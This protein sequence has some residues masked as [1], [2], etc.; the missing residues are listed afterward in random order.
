MADKINQEGINP[1]DSP[2][3]DSH[4]NLVNDYSELMEHEAF[5]GDTPYPTIIESI[6]DQFDNY[7]GMEDRTDYV[8]IF[9]EQLH[10]SYNTAR[11]DDD[12]PHPEELVEALDRIHEDFIATMQEQFQSRLTLTIMPLEAEDRDLDEVEMII[13]KLY[14]YFIIGARNNFI[15]V[16]KN[17]IIATLP[18]IVNDSSSDEYFQRIKN[19]MTCYSPLFSTI[20]PQ[21]FLKLSDAK[22]I[23]K[24]FNE[25][26]VV[27][28]FLRKYSPKFYRNDDFQVEV[29]NEVAITHGFL[30]DIKKAAVDTFEIPRDAVFPG[31]DPKPAEEVTDNE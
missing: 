12:K 13:R 5:L 8:D 30:S 11:A 18:P 17:D 2:Y 22:H 26:K 9:Y 31:S 28:N 21:K 16:I 19:K 20:D 24:L 4:D 27:G 10:L 15:S 3:D 23:A 14:E 6:K 25:G 29:I 7:V 1:L